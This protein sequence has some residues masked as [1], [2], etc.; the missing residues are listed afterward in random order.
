MGQITSLVV[1]DGTANQTF[2]FSSEKNG[3]LGENT[4][5]FENRAVGVPLGFPYII[6]TTR[7]GLPADTSAASVGLEV[8]YPITLAAT[9]TTPTTVTHVLRFKDGRYYL[10]KRST[11]AE[12]TI[13]SNLVKNLHAHASITALVVNAE[14]AWN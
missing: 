8:A 3:R 14:Q 7:P 2:T 12:R 11:T 1:N 13:L 4:L 9:S 10:P 5:T 6:V